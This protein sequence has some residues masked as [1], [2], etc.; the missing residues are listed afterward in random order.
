MLYGRGPECARIDLLVD[1]ARGGRSAVLVL[2]GEAGIG[3]SALLR[4][5]ADAAE[6]MLVLRGTGIETESEL[7]FAGVHRLLR[8][9]AGLVDRLPEPQR[10][11]L[12]GVFGHAPVSRTDK[13]LAS[14]AVLNLL[15]E[16]ATA[17]PTLCL[18]DD[19]Q[20][21]DSASA[22][23][24]TF[25]ARRIEAEGIAMVFAARD[26]PMR[27]FVAPDLPQLVVGG[28]DADAIDAL[29]AE[30]ASATVAGTV[31]DRLL[32]GTLGN[33]LALTELA[34][35][36]TSSQLTGREPLPVRLPV[37]A[38]VEQLFG[39]RVS[40]QPADTR[41]LLLIAAASD[42]DDLTTVFRAARA[43]DVKADALDAAEAAGLVVVSGETIAFRHP[44]VRSAV[45]RGATAQARRAVERALGDALDSERDADRRAW[46]RANAAIGP[47]DDVAAALAVVAER[48]VDRGGH[49]A[50][51]AAYVR[52]AELTTD[53]DSRA[54]RLVSAAEAAWAAGRP[55][56]ARDLLERASPAKSQLL[57]RGRAA[58]LLGAIDT[59]CGTP[60][61]AY[62]T[63]VEGA[64][65][66]ADLD[67]EQAGLMIAEAGQIAWG[68]GD[69]ARIVAAGD[70]LA[71]LPD[72][73]NPGSRAIVGLARLMQGDP[74]A[75]ST[76]LT[77][78][79]D[80]A[81]GSGLPQ[82]VMLAAAGAMFV[83]DDVR[84]VDLF[85]RAVAR[86]RSA[87]AAATLPI[88][89]APLST[90]EMFTGRYATAA[91]DATEGLRLATETG[92][93]NPAAHA[94]SVLA[95]L[96]AVQ[97]RDADCTG[98]ADLALAH[99]IGQ[100]LG[101]HAAIATW[102][103]AH[104][105]LASGRAAH[106]LE[107]LLA[108][109]D[110]A[111][112]EG[113]PMVSLF[114]TA[115]LVD[116]AVRVDRGRE[117]AT[118]VDRLEGWAAHTNAA[119]TAALVARCRAQLATDDAASDALFDTSLD[120]YARG[121]RPFDTARTA[122]LFGARLRRRRRRADARKHLRVAVE[123]FER[124]GAAPWAE[125]ARAELLATGET[126]RKRDVS[127]L[128]TLTPQEL[129][130]ARLV[131]NGATNRAIAAHLFLSP[132]TV[133]Y[134]LRKVFSKLG[135][136]S[137]HDLVRLSLDDDGLASH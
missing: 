69:L 103:L 102:A 91:T 107:R 44:L 129:Q 134:H 57:L 116:A 35:T 51:A 73:G 97:G 78:A 24:L 27:P 114:A 65:L 64:E 47:D 42:S 46:H 13:W 76:E 29:L 15:A 12:R 31:R 20:W 14:L 126:A 120:L 131:A 26:D 50:A 30:R 60:A 84:A 56:D 38:D 75:A 70:R 62:A 18:V 22:D 41:T 87:G 68:T 55:D 119:W 128:K 9:V 7:P 6:G 28:L 58:H 49:A 66:I 118:A 83:G 108:L 3:K 53:P 72:S 63:L 89:L 111:P 33:P 113:N 115:D 93:D 117:A 99:A 105:D 86:A 81:H 34:G 8:P 67:P 123:T 125:Q 40:T 79:A 98:L 101:P 21:L 90:I 25:V 109:A 4:H 130:I 94:R 82:M 127:T 85:T 54:T 1:A 74:A 110:A 104:C 48:A 132:R 19:A 61:V 135:I 122:L 71:T 52:A 43:L 32:A 37:G 39:D 136:S 23:A 137:R 80:I 77:A 45:Y 10:D 17:T 95:W 92:Q 2:R 16:A 121:G 96:A 106:A 133:D 112:G 88:L 59:A 5:A 36:L 124:L 100:R 11:A